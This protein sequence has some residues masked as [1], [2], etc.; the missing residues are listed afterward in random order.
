MD[1]FSASSSQRYNPDLELMLL[2]PMRL[3]KKYDM[4]KLIRLLIPLVEAQWPRTLMEWDV[5]TVHNKKHPEAHLE[6]AA[7]IVLATEHNITSIL[8]AAYY[9]LSQ[10]GIYDDYD[11]NGPKTRKLTARWDML[12]PRDYRR[13]IY[14]KET[15]PG[16]IESLAATVFRCS[17]EQCGRK[18]ALLSALRDQR[19][20]LSIITPLDLASI[21][22]S[23]CR[24]WMFRDPPRILRQKAWDGLPVIFNFGND[25]SA[26]PEIDDFRAYI[27]SPS[28]SP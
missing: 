10:I 18:L 23:S 21:P 15:L 25:I 28:T 4:D 17:S 14:G 1:N 19:D 13:L 2:E 24:S 8:P 11:S 22:C 3:A 20:F 26:F 16:I 9:L 5:Y 27:V 6:P 12:S 7:A